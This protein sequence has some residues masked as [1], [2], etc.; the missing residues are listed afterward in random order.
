MPASSTKWH[1]FKTTVSMVIREF[2]MAAKISGTLVVTVNSK[3]VPGVQRATS[4]RIVS[5]ETRE[6]S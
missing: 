2:A 3:G 1:N 4:A 5:N 6:K